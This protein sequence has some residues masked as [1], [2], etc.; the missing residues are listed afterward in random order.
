MRH[1]T[2]SRLSL[3]HH[4]LPGSLQFSPRLSAN[5]RLHQIHSVF[6]FAASVRANQSKHSHIM[7]YYE[8]RYTGILLWSALHSKSSPWNVSEILDNCQ[9]LCVPVDCSALGPVEKC[10]CHASA[11]QPEPIVASHAMDHPPRTV[12]HYTDVLYAA[13]VIFK[14][15]KATYLFISVTRSH[16]GRRFYQLPQKRCIKWLIHRPRPIRSYIINAHTCAVRL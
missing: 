12:S 6:N 7:E 9:I 3:G 5:F 16:R 10:R 1:M 4:D 14:C 11:N 15:F 8:E 2:P 13:F